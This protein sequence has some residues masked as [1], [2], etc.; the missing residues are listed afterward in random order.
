MLRHF[1][2]TNNYHYFFN[3]PKKKTGAKKKADK[4][5]E[6]QKEIKTS[7]EARSLVHH[8]CNKLMV[9]KI[10]IIVIEIMGCCNAILWDIVIQYPSFMKNLLIAMVMFHFFILGMRQM[11][12]VIVL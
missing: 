11:S 2:S 5:R 3:M 7:S 8:P 12:K 10:V 6:R 4:Q 9:S 1:F